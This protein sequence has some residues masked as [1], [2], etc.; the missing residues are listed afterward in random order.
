MAYGRLTL[1]QELALRPYVRGQLVH[2][3]GAGDLVVAADLLR[4]GAKQVVALDKETYRRKAPQ[5]ITPVTCY[6]EDYPAPVDIAFMSWPR[7]TFDVGL[8]NICRRARMVIYL[9]NNTGG[10]ACSFS[11]LSQHLAT[12]QVLVHAPNEYNSLIVY[13]SVLE[14]RRYL[15]EEYAAIFQDKQWDYHELQNISDTLPLV[16]APNRFGN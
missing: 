14:S 13:S 7:N 2:D 9:G 8:L 4:L 15:P 1:E 11:A 12:R 16:S 3:L 10:Q 5:G 6:F